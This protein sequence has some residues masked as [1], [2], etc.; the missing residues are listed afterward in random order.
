[1]TGDARIHSIMRSGSSARALRR[2][3]KKNTPFGFG[4]VVTWL[5]PKGVFHVLCGIC[6]LYEMWPAFIPLGCI[7]NSWLHNMKTSY[8]GVEIIGK[9]IVWSVAL[10][11]IFGFLS[12]VLQTWIGR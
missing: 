4:L 7:K 6:G 9:E 3:H 1:M 2:I 10:M 8:A 5:K 11:V 12:T